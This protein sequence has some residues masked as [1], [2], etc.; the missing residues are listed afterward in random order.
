MKRQLNQLF[1][2]ESLP[3]Q[4]ILKYKELYKNRDFLHP[5]IWP[6]G[7]KQYINLYRFNLLF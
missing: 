2:V 3:I 1:I 5:Y 7:L 4:K 6:E